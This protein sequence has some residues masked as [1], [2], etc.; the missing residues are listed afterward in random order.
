MSDVRSDLTS[1]RAMLATAVSI[2]VV[3]AAAPIFVPSAQA[4]RSKGP[5]NVPVE[6]LMKTDT[7]LPE[8]VIG[9]PEALVTIVEYASMTCGH[10]AAFHLTVLPKLKE[11]Y[12]DTGK[13]KLVFREFPL[14]NLAA[15]VSMLSRCVGGE[16]PPAFIS[17]MFKRQPEWAFG[18]GNP[19]P[20]LFEM[21]RQVGFTQAS[22]DKCLSDTK[23]L[24]QIEAGRKRASEKFGVD[25]TPTF[26]INGKRLAGVML[27]DFEKAIDP[28]LKA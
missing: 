8:I 25:A 13:V 14:D 16:G 6:E 11:K 3:A 1:R 18:S 26:F 27:P 5:A 4:Q 21:A 19:I 28:L 23:L 9:K 7:D 17:E 15:A 22:F 20:R 24:E 10:C 2:S 12:I